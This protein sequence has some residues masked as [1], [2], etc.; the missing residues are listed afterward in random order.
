MLGP[1]ASNKDSQAL[2]QRLQ[3]KEAQVARNRLK[4]LD[5]KKIKLEQKQRHALMVLERKRVMIEEGLV[6]PCVGTLGTGFKK[7]AGFRS[8][9]V[10]DDG[11]FSRQHSGNSVRSSVLDLPSTV[12]E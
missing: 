6:E 11:Y 1:I 10:V 7:A 9:K 4:E 8:S 5:K 12:C 3:E 2:R